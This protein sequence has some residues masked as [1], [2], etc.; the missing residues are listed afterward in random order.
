M[1]RT[2]SKERSGSSR[3]NV[4]HSSARAGRGSTGAGDAGCSMHRCGRQAWPRGRWHECGC[5]SA[6]ACRYPAPPPPPAPSCPACLEHALP[7]P[8]DIPSRPRPDRLA[9]NTP[10]PSACCTTTLT[11]LPSAARAVATSRTISS[12]APNGSS[13][14]STGLD[15]EEQAWV[16]ESAFD[17]LHATHMCPRDTRQIRC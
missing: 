15:A 14:G 9:W 7:Q 4:D 12:T 2:G 1:G 11:R 16:H 3:L 17:S 8:A 13:S 6:P 10:C 5:T